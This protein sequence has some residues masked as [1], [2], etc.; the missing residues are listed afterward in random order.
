MSSRSTH[1]TTVDSYLKPHILPT[2]YIDR[3]KLLSA[4]KTRYG[5]DF[6]VELRLN[7]YTIFIP[8][9]LDEVG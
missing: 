8:D 6:R 5:P 3:K 1:P 7:Q 4:L 9:D 2:P